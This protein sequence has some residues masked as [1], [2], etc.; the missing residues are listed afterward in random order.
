MQVILVPEGGFCFGVRRAMEMA[1]KAIAES[2]G[3]ATLGPLIH[4]QE[5]VDR[6][7]E[8]GLRAIEK[9]EEARPGEV[10]MLRTHGTGPATIQALAERGVTIVDAT[11]PFVARAQREA[12]RFQEE[13]YDVLVL[14]EPDHP[15]AIGIAEHTG[16]AARIIERAGDLRDQ[17]L[18]KRVAVVCQTT[19]RL[20]RLQE[21]VAMLLPRCIELRVANTICD[22]TSKRQEASVQVARQVDLMLVVGGRH[23]ANTTRLAQIC[24]ETGTPTHHIETAEELRPEWL[25]GVERVGVT[26]GASTPDWIIAAVVARLET[27]GGTVAGSRG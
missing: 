22:A 24:A 19:Q 23:S 15:E 9:V 7:A 10:V 25:A 5:A 16:G 11:C 20:D 13:G 2:G 21:L 1:E 18:R 26:A 14:G 12:R 6:L 27:L 4:N 8:Q 3:G 17:P